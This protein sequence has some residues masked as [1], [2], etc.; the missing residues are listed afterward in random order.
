MGWS[1]AG[2]ESLFATSKRLSGPQLPVCGCCW[3]LHH[4][5]A[6]KPG[7][8]K[9]AFPTQLSRSLWPAGSSW[10]P[11]ENQLCPAISGLVLQSRLREGRREDE[12][13]VS[14]PPKTF[15]RGV[16]SV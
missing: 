13:I 8:K 10:E 12:A 1:K 14:C 5:S 16:S 9:I 3:H 4:G 7:A 6:W 11:T 2:G 15:Q